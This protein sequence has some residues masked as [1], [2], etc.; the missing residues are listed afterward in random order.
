M[1]DIIRDSS[2][3][4]VL[5]Y[6][7]GNRILLFPD[8]LPG[9]ELPSP[10][11]EEKRIEYQSEA[12]TIAN[13]GKD[14]NGNDSSPDEEHAQGADI[15]VA[16][17]VSQPVHPVLTFNGIIL[18][19]WY[20]TGELDDKFYT[21]AVYIGSSIYSPGEGE[22]EEK[23]NVGPTAAAL[24]MSLYVLA[25]GIG[26][27]LWSP[28]SEIP[29]VGKN[30]PYI[31]T[32][33][34]FVILTVPTALTDSFAGLL[35]LRF[36][37]G[38]F[39]SPCLATA[40]A[41]FQD[42]WPLIKI[43]YLMVIWA[44]FATLGPAFGPVV[45]GF[46]I[47]AKNWRWSQWEMLWL[48]GPIFLLM[49]FSLPETSPATIL[50]QRARRLRKLLHKS[51]L[52]SQSE[53]DQAHMTAKERAFDAL[54]KPWE[55]NALDPAVLFSTFYTS[56]LY[57]IFY[58]FF[59]STPLVFPRI[60]HF[61]LGESGL[62]YLSALGA[63]LAVGPTYAAYWHYTVERQ[64]AKKGFGPQ[65]DRLA[66]GLV[67]SC[68]IP[69]GLFLYAWTARS[70]VHWIAPTFGLG[71]SVG[72]TFLIIQSIFLYLPFTYPKYS[73]SLFAAND[74]AR[75]TMA[76]GAILFSRP[77]FIKLG[78]AGGVSLLGGLTIVCAFLLY[79]LYRYGAVLRAK[80]RFAEHD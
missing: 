66:V 8:E 35:V 30:P 50:L 37:L 34:V 55:I 69:V 16:R 43:P 60:Y 27:M 79:L 40:G 78:V 41:S 13:F 32:F 36:L 75:S 1:Y 45:A 70:S 72:G 20:T 64:F 44:G 7:T 5:R 25:Y 56:L 3:G 46:S 15:P 51:N 6:F 4:Q 53:I 28:L 23:F 49:F 74:L 58:S 31:L 17:T 68:M 57:G 63:L 24:G 11:S 80:S 47:Q 14:V 59:E 54:I 67:G 22:I 52:K 19:D 9:F 71:L 2:F 61:N 10:T 48:S 73:A 29:V 42:M 18:V 65:E 26:P 77:L 21:F 62:P 33:A 76:A 12:S 39:G 38:F